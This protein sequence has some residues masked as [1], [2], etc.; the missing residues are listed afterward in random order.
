MR[1]VCALTCGSEGH[2]RSASAWVRWRSVAMFE[3]PVNF[4]RYAAL[5]VGLAYLIWLAYSRDWRRFGG[6]GL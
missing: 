3:E 6:P 4:Q 2:G 5:M 1:E